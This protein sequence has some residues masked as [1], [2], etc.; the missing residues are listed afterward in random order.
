MTTDVQSATFSELTTLGV[1]GPV[2]R[3]VDATTEADL[4]DAVRTADDEGVPVLVLGGGSNLLVSDAGFDG[5]VVRD[6]RRDITTPDHSACAGVTLTAV[7]G[8]V[9]DDVVAHAAAHR[10][11]GI[12]A[13]S[14]I[15]GSTGATPVQN[16]GAYGQEVS[17]T[18]ATVR[19]WD[20]QRSR[21]RT[22]PVADLQFGYRTSLLKRSM[23]SLPD[24]ADPGAPWFPTPRYVVLDVTF[25]LR[26]A[27]LSEPI[28]YGELARALGVEVGE[29]APLP[30]VRAAVLALRGRKGM[31]LD[32]ADPDT[33]SAGSFFTNPVLA[34]ADAAA[35]PEGAPRFPAGDGLVKSSAAWLIEQAGFAKGYGLPGPAALSTKH[36]L[37]LTN[38][39][40]ANAGDLLALARTVR[41]GVA[42]QFGIVLEPEPVLVGTDL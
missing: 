31:V 29:R 41:D 18:I 21:V 42:Q 40:G 16:V 15:P 3:L 22:L 25:Q 10:L 2:D 4:I 9:W 17:Q 12:E 6:A 32:A 39:G 36:T 28:A 24:E 33:R 7:A 1:G 23:R 37:A 27:D 11:K 14:G 13:L 20:R 34:E 35:L 8:A 26:V 19:V 38:R 5:L 30:D